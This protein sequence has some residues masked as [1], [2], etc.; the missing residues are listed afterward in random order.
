MRMLLCNSECSYIYIQCHI[1]RYPAPSQID[2]CICMYEEYLIRIH[3]YFSFSV[4][5][6][7]MKSGVQGRLTS[8]VSLKTVFCTYFSVLL[9]F[10]FLSMKHV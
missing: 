3:F 6:L 8:A 2:V 5:L 1:C 7:R 10:I 9:L 4:M